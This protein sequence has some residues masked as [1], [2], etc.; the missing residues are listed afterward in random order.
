M[1]NFATYRNDWFVEGNVFS[2][3]CHKTPLMISQHWFRQQAITWANVDSDFWRHRAPLGHIEL[4]QH[5][6]DVKMSAMASQITSLMMVC[7]TVCSDVNQRKHQGSAS[8]AF[9]RGIHH[10]PMNSS[11]KRPVTLKMFPVDDVIMPHDEFIMSTYM[12]SG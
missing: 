1:C 12:Y 2:G 6:N 5:Y 7:S 11:H 9:V 3:E 4:T 10:W 8:L